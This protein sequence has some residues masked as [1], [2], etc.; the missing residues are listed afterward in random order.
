MNR[1][2][3]AKAVALAEE[4]LTAASA[5]CAQA[6]AEWRESLAW[7]VTQENLEELRRRSDAM[8]EA[9]ALQTAAIKRRREL[10]D[11][12]IDAS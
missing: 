3:L 5:R 10:L 2:E 4:A 1:D 6:D 8:R 11:A 12:Q 7:D 9:L